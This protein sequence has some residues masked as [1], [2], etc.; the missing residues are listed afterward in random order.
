MEYTIEAS[1]ISMASFDLPRRGKAR[2]SLGMV[3]VEADV[4]SGANNKKT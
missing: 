4:G 3:S 1:V 2:E